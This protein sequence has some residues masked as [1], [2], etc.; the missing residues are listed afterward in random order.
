MSLWWLRKSER[1]EWSEYEL[2]STGQIPSWRDCLGMW[3]GTSGGKAERKKADQAGRGGPLAI[4]VED[5]GWVP[6]AHMLAH[7]SVML[8]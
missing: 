3:W 6:S 7:S 5:Q 1:Q 2:S 8:F 4:L